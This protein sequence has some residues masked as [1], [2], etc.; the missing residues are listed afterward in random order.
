MNPGPGGGTSEAA[1]LMITASTPQSQPVISNVVPASAPLST[2]AT[3]TLSGNGF[4]SGPTVAFDGKAIS[5]SYVNSTT[6]TAQRSPSELLIPGN[7]AITVNTPGVGMSSAASFTA[8]IG[9]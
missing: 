3:I 1:T 8:Y 2:S 4:D 9:V 5:S 6:M 7:Y